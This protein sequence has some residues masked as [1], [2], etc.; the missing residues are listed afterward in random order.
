L[1][2]SG[3]KPFAGSATNTFDLDVLAM[4]GNSM[5]RFLCQSSFIRQA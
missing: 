4:R 5:R 1:F 3:C 2:V